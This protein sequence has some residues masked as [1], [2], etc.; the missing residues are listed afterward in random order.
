[1]ISVELAEPVLGSVGVF[2]GLPCSDAPGLSVA[3]PGVAVSPVE[4]LLTV[5][6]GAVGAGPSVVELEHPEAAFYT[7][8]AIPAM[9]TD[10]LR[11]VNV[12]I[13]SPPVQPCPSCQV[14]PPIVV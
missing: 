12:C 13:K 9:L 8:P 10:L 1:M 14:E 4:V 3:G 2:T 6:S 5:V 7:L 11:A